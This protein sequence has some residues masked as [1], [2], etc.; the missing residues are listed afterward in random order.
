MDKK[1]IY[2]K[3]ILSIKSIFDSDN[4][5]S[6]QA[7]MAITNALIIMEF[8]NLIFCGFYVMNNKNYL[9]IGPYQ[10]KILACTKIKI[11][12]G[13]CGSVAS[14]KKTLIVNDVTT[15][16]NY[17]SCDPKTRSEIVVPIIKENKLLAVLDIDSE[18]VGNFNKIDKLYLEKIAHLLV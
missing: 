9:E 8:P 6:F 16:S 10:G 3:I 11:G 2:K 5:I 4:S 12:Q 13:V 7:K 18:A 14:N 1:K 17:I 15:Y